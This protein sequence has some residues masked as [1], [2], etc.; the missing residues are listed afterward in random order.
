MDFV[1]LFYFG[2]G[3]DS[4]ENVFQVT[5]ITEGKERAGETRRWKHPDLSLAAPL[6]CGRELKQVTS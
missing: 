6:H 5:F 1:C 4:P 3:G 2:F